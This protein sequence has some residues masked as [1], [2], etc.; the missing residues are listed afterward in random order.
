MHW[1]AAKPGLPLFRKFV[2]DRVAEATKARSEIQSL[3]DDTRRF[4][5]EQKHRAL[6]KEVDLVRVPGDAV[7]SAFFAEAKAKAREKRRT[8]VERSYGAGGG[9]R[10][11]FIVHT[12]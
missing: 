5:L 8:T 9:G 7:L 4:I 10:G 6:E 1:D 2:A 11:T 3:P 12:N